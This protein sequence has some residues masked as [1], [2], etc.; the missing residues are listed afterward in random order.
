MKKILCN[1]CRF[2]EG[3]HFLEQDDIDYYTGLK[4]I[5]LSIW[6]CNKCPYITWLIR[7]FFNNKINPNLRRYIINV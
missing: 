5:D 1:I 6:V 3:T 7:E 4:D 2:R